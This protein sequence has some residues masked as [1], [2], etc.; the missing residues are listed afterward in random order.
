MEMSFRPPLIN[1]F[2]VWVYVYIR[3]F[4]SLRDG[5]LLFCRVFS[6]LFISPFSFFFFS[7]LRGVGFLFLFVFSCSL[8]FGKLFLV[9]VLGVTKIIDL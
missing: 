6:G 3:R 2:R 1:V 7:F 5:M 8:Y 4:N 9:L